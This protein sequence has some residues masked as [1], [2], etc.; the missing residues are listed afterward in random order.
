ML[1]E[2]RKQINREYKKSL[3]FMLYI[4]IDF[5]DSECSEERIIGFNI[6]VFFPM[7]PR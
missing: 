6:C 7:K 2:K 1:E 3:S 5:L 4:I